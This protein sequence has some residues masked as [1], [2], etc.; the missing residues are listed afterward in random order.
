MTVEEIMRQIDNKRAE[1]RRLT[2]ETW[3]APDHIANTVEPRLKQLDL[4]IIDLKTQ[5]YKASG[6]Q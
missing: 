2:R 3:G 1:Q 6:G 5:L 4:E